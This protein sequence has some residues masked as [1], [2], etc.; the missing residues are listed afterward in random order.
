MSCIIKL[1][2]NGWPWRFFLA[3]IFLQLPIY[4]EGRRWCDVHRKG[5][6]LDDCF[7]CWGYFFIFVSLNFNHRH[8]KPL[9]YK[10]RDMLCSWTLH[11]SASHGP[12]YFCYY[13]HFN[14]KN[15]YALFTFGLLERNPFRIFKEMSAQNEMRGQ[16]VK[17]ILFLF[18]G[19]I[20]LVL[21]STVVTTQVVVC[22][23]FSGF[24]YPIHVSRFLTLV[25]ILMVKVTSKLSFITN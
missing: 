21:F 6:W 2:Y 7:F 15:P 25:L 22:G 11:T 8:H 19:V 17:A 12:L 24:Q 5:K 23:L 14:K 10:Y 9:A 18:E 3:R 20:S 13:M 4:I 16:E 1:F